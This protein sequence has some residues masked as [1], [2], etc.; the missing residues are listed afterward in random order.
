M[1]RALVATES[2][3]LYNEVQLALGSHRITTVEHVQDLRTLH[4]LVRLASGLGEAEQVLV[5]LSTRL[6]LSRGLESVLDTDDLFRRAGEHIVPILLIDPQDAGEES[7]LARMTGFTRFISP[8][9]QALELSRRLGVILGI[10]TPH[11]AEPAAP[12]GSLFATSARVVPSQTQVAAYPDNPAPRDAS[13]V[14]TELPAL[15]RRGEEALPPLRLL[16]TLYMQGTSGLL[17]LE[18]GASTLEVAVRIGAAGR[19][20]GARAVPREQLAAAI[21]SPR[22]RATFVPGEV[23]AGSFERTAGLLSLL[24]EAAQRMPRE[25]VRRRSDARRERYPAFTDLLAQRQRD[26]ARYDGLLTFCQA[27]QG[28]EPWQRLLQRLGPEAERWAI[29]A[30]ETDLLIFRD[31]PCK[32]PLTVRYVGLHDPAEDPDQ[33]VNPPPR[34]SSTRNARSAPA[35]HRELIEGMEQRLRQLK[36]SDPYAAFDLEPGCG[37]SAARDAFRRIVKEHH[38]DVYGG[39]IDAAVKRLA[40][41]IFI[42]YKNLHQRLSRQEREG[43]L[44]PPPVAAP[45]ASTDGLFKRAEPPRGTLSSDAARP[46]PRAS[47][48]ARRPPWAGAS[49]PTGRA[50]AARAEA[51]RNDTTTPPWVHEERRAAPAAAPKPQRPFTSTAK[52]PAVVPAA[53]PQRPEDPLAE[54]ERLMRANQTPQALAFFQR[55]VEEAPEEPRRLAWYRWALYLTSGASGETTEREL[56]LLTQR[57]PACLDAWL[58]LGKLSKL[59]HKSAQALAAFQRAL[60]LDPDHS[61]AQREARLLAAE[62]PPT[63]ATVPP[64]RE[65]E[66]QRSF[67]GRFFNKDKG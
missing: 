23:R 22:L 41:D 55:L 20:R 40:E 45:P 60:E 39:N 62:P 30:E 57:H 37:V 8:P 28:A 26:L 5:F 47:G 42:E 31:A 27:C 24:Y 50:E 53:A 66:G 65:R 34:A 12:S 32:A 61:E 11:R 13:R 2:P 38:P 56:A 35:D 6:L 19:Q 14:T 44:T 16:Y 15:N 21:A 4:M 51:A 29:Y 48:P 36:A 25:E 1:S 17:R 54:G 33:T 67:L 3:A 64:A 49:S 46:A 7:S 10:Q 63:P 52:V 59:L 18:D 9:L 58:L 43:R